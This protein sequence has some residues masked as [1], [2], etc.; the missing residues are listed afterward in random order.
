VWDEFQVVFL[1]LE[2]NITLIIRIN[3]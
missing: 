3:R 2:V 1:P